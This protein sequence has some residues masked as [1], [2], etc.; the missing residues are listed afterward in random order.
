[1]DLSV[2]V[3]K[4]PRG[5]I[6]VIQCIMAILAFS[7]TAGFSTSCEFSI[8]CGDGK[9]VDVN[10][11]FGYPFEKSELLVPDTCASNERLP[12]K[13]P[14]DY[15]TIAEFY[16]T[17][18]VLAFLYTLGILVVYIFFHQSY[19]ENSKLPALDLCAT[20][21]FTI[22]WMAGSSAWAQGVVDLKYYMDPATVIQY[23][24]ICIRNHSENNCMT[25]DDGSYG[26][27]NASLILGFA[28]FLLWLVSLWFIYKETDFHKTDLPQ[29]APQNQIP[30]SVGRPVDIRKV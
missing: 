2:R 21:I 26:T 1:M 22:F 8:S 19:S 5:F 28:N 6:R 30:K 23:L 17:T 16:V 9:I 7:T 3:M 25:E 10:Y 18:G 15:S 4:E 29:D 27:L 14:F 24:F 13:L 12:L 20:A 11:T